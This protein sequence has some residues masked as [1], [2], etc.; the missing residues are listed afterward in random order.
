MRD[1]D[2]EMIEARTT[3]SR[4]KSLVHQGEEHDAKESMCRALRGCYNDS[5]AD[6]RKYM[7]GLYACVYSV[8]TDLA[9]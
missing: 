4:Q 8:V 5:I 9:L 7:F 2:Y 3:D 6:A 1:N